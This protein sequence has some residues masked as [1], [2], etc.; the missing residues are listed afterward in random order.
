MTITKNNNIDFLKKTLL[1]KNM[2]EDEIY[3]CLITYRIYEK[4]YEKNSVI[5][6]ATEKTEV[7]GLV[8][9]GS[10]TIESNDLWGNRTILSYIGRGGFFAETYAV[11]KT[12]PLSVDVVSN[13][14]CRI[15][16]LR[17]GLLQPANVAFENRVQ[18]E[19]NA[20]IWKFKFLYNLLQVSSRK[21]LHL[22][23]RS[24]HTA[25]KTIRAKVMAYL[26]TIS[27]QKQ[28]CEFNIPFDRQQLADYLNVDRTALSKELGKM[29]KDG[30]IATKKNHFILYKT[31]N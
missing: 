13:E 11:L 8:L 18:P 6:Y 12:V 2:N 26:N 5:L 21:N 24:F 31:E 19:N 16:F 27:V 29:Q 22:S 14:K 10:V 9:E 4:N 20:P 25:P 23:A 30:L 15:L 7:M 28:T 1:F 3:K 17:I